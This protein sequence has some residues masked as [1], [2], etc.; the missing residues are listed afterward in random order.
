MVELADF[1]GRLVFAR[2]N[3]Y[4]NDSINDLAELYKNIFSE[5]PYNEN[6]DKET[7]FN[8][9]KKQAE[10]NTIILLEIEDRVKGFILLEHGEG[11]H[12]LTKSITK[13]LKYINFDISRSIYIADIGVSKDIRGKGLGKLL[14]NYVID[15]YGPY[16]PLYLRTGK[17]KN[18]KTIGFYKKLGFTS[19]DIEEAVENLRIDGNIYSDTRFYMIRNC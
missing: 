19:T 8:D 15:N 6:F 17:Y 14:M 7:L 16:Q 2:H 18:D 10:I 4:W 5:P 12:V 13:R 1:N 11:S 9:F 3:D